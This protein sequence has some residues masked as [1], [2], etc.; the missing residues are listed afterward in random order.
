MNAGLEFLTAVTTK[1]YILWEVTPCDLEK[2]TYI[3]E[4]IITFIFIAE[5]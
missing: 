4:E 1:V 5:E 3:S 2:S